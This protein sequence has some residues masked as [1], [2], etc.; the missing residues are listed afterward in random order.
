M[1]LYPVSDISSDERM[2]CFV[3]SYNLK[4]PV[5]TLVFTKCSVIGQKLSQCFRKCLACVALIRL[6]NYHNFFLKMSHFSD[7]GSDRLSL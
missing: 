3:L 1:V 7:T 6:M 2:Q 5:H 4:A